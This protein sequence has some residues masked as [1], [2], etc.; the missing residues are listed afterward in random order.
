MKEITKNVFR[1]FLF[2][3]LGLTIVS[4]AFASYFYPPGQPGKPTYIAIM[5]YGCVIKYSAPRNNGG[6]PI[7]G[8][9]IEYKSENGNKW[10]KVNRDPILAL[11]CVITNI[12][13]GDTGRFRVTARNDAGDSKPSEVSDPITFKD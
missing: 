9:F 6:L 13:E 4:M 3:C 11:E 5:S 8:Y 12:K 1:T 7:T 10:I 2:V